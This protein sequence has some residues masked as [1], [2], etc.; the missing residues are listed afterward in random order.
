MKSQFKMRISLIFFLFLVQFSQAQLANFSLTVT[1]T[2]ESCTGNGSLS[3]SVSGTTAGATI[4]YSIYKFPNLTTPIAV[5]VASNF[6]GLASGNYRVIATQTLGNLSNTQQQDIQII[7]TRTVVSYQLS[8]QAVSCNNGS[9]IVS[10]LSGNPVSYE[11][12]SGPV[13]VPPQ[14]SNIFQN[15]PS[16]TYNIRVNDGCNEGVVQSYTL[17][18]SNPPN[19][20]LDSFHTNCQ[21]NSCNTLS[22]YFNITSFF[23][24][25]IRYP[26]TIQT[27]VFP[28]AS[29]A[30]TVLNQTLNSGDSTT[31]DVFLTLP[32][33]YNQ[34]YTFNV[35]VTDACGN[36]YHSDGNQ[37]IK[38]LS[39][40][41]AYTYSNCLKGID[42]TACNFMPPYTVNFVFAPSG[43]NPSDYN[44][45]HP[46]PFTSTASYLSTATNNLPD[47][48]YIIEI[49]DAC[50]H[51]AQTQVEVVPPGP[52]YLLIPNPDI[53]STQI[54][55]QIYSDIVSAIITSA[56]AALNHT[57]PYDVSFNISNG[58]F[59][60]A[61]P[62]G[63]Y[64]IEGA[65]ACGNLY[66]FTI[67]VPPKIIDVTAL[68]VNV[69]GCSGPN[70]AINITAIGAQL[71]S[72]SI[73]QAPVSYNQTLP[74]DASASIDTTYYT[75][76]HIMYLPSG[77]YTLNITDSC[78]NH[79][80]KTVTIT[81]VI[82][83]APLV[84]YEK[85]G[86]G[87]NFDSISLSSPNGALQS[88]IITAAPLSFPFPLPYN[89]SSNINSGGYFYMNSLPE[90][91]YVFYSK[92]VCNVERTE[93]LQLLGY[94]VVNN[95]I[96]VIPNC[97][98]FNLDMHFQDNNPSLHGFW[99]QKYDPISN[100]WVHPFTN[101]LYPANS[102]PNASNSYSLTNNTINY[103]I[104]VLG[105]FRIV[106][107]YDYYS[108]GSSTLTTCVE[109]VKTFDFTGELK[110]ISAY[111]LPC[112]N[113][114]SQVVITANG[115]P[116]LHYKITTKDGLPFFVDNSNSNVF[117]G[118]QPGIYNF[119]VEDFCGN[120]VNRLFDITSLPEPAITPNNLCSGLNGSLSVQ[121][122]AFLNYQWWE[123]TNTTTI[124]STTNV[125]SFNPF[126]NT[127]SPGTYYVRIYSSDG[128]SCVDKIL[129]YTIPAVNAPN[130]GLDG[131]LVIC[132]ASGGINLFS[133]L[134]GA[135]DTGGVWQE[136]TSSGMLS[137]S[138]WLPVGI[139]FG[140][141]V[142]K[143]TVSGF[144]NSTDE[145]VVT[146]QYNSA[147]DTPI[148]AV[149]PTYCSGETIQFNIQNFANATYQWSGPNNFSSTLQNPT[150]VNSTVGD[151]GTYTITVTV[152]GCLASATVDVIVHAVPSYTY[153]AS[154]LGGAY[155][156][157]IV[158]VDDSFSANSATYQWTGPN[159]FTSSQ[160]PLILTNQ[161][162]GDYSVIVTNTEGCSIP[163]TINIVNTFCDFPNVITPNNDGS[164]DSFDLT[165]YDVA[166]FQ[167]YNRWGRL[168]YEQNN[169]TNQWYGQNKNEQIL[170]DST[171]YY[172]L[173]MRSG[174]E[175]HGWVLITAK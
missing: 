154:C 66:N 83:Q 60:M 164:N 117:S 97:G 87:E 73:T 26:L 10:V 33:Y 5:T 174:E 166:V 138:S 86:C 50:G 101:V 35:Q 30:P 27:T 62:A 78:G 123:G 37:I 170:P 153:E 67:E 144:C 118:L 3:F 125:L 162:R 21:F 90:G 85:Q 29:G 79:Y 8:S 11:I 65:D 44:A 139:P 34:L 23:N 119:R 91:T 92:D 54:I 143:Y 113:G 149:N 4:T 95:N 105:T 38:Q 71:A 72:I 158:P 165:G 82:S 146:I 168:V 122:L 81:T 36:V 59:N 52:K 1:K 61:L 142:F 58:I 41:A 159:G 145:S 173:Q 161:P 32:F 39:V 76:A 53:C 68:G 112:S 45:T 98:S 40:S 24:T 25:T 93:T 80:I 107:Q 160:N 108:N 114:V 121:P 111:L 133:L 16:G 13:I 14:S 124:L 17:T 70:G 120:I 141:Y 103:N 6:T 115:T 7:D 12:I 9:I 20:I 130:A 47:G 150:I 104:A 77:N 48:V 42:I 156:V 140:T 157:L 155:T 99:L 69:T 18:F 43:F 135:Y 55:V 88:V 132:G 172:Y 131:N 106:M 128:T 129:S 110:I 56:P 109:P 175:K 136:T 84:F 51:S 19:L 127:T 75:T 15:L 96:Q 102:V 126:S 152:N 31:Q 148:I 28:P 2:D 169:Y 57:L 64:V 89:V 151:S 63:T 22:G 100:Q 147:T 74:Y 94:H 163:Q 134:V 49:T 116:P 167:V 171:Y 46:G 137:G